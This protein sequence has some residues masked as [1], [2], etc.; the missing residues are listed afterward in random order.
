IDTFLYDQD[1]LEAT[2]D[3]KAA[4]RARAEE[5]E[6]DT[7]ND[8]LVGE[9]L[10]REFA[11]TTAALRKELALACGQPQTEGRN[12]PEARASE[13]K[14]KNKNN[15]EEKKSGNANAKPRNEPK[16]KNQE[17]NPKSK[18]KSK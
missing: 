14:T 4:A 1:Q 9:L 15:K 7:N 10:K 12:R 18:P 5:M 16:Q 13:E 6:V 3:I 17:K 2:R 11:K 8:I